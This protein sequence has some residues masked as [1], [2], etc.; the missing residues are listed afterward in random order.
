MADVR[1]HAYPGPEHTAYMADAELKKLM[2]T[3]GWKPK[4]EKTS[5]EQE[6]AQRVTPPPAA[7]RRTV[8]KKPARTASR[9]KK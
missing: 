3:L 9:R 7:T 2:K 8:A 1:S 5:A 6:A 4:M